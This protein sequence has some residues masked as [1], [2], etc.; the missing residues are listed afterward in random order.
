MILENGD[1]TVWS[2]VR[3]MAVCSEMC[4]A[5][6]IEK[7]AVGS[8]WVVHRRGLTVENFRGNLGL[9]GEELV[10]RI[11]KRKS[12]TWRRVQSRRQTVTGKGPQGCKKCQLAAAG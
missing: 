1:N 8:I 6:T 2:H 12:G 5:P 3:R 7:K 4:T 10:G 11:S 9:E